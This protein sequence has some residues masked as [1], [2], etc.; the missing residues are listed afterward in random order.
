[1]VMLILWLNEWAYHLEGVN[2]MDNADFYLQDLKSK[3][4]KIN[5]KEYYLSYSGGKD[6]HL[7]YWFIKEY[8][9][10]FSNIKVIGINTYLEHPEIRDRIY[11]YS[12][13]V[14]LPSKIPFEIKEEFGIPCFSKEQD[15]FIYFG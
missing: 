13:K 1:M 5:P 6:S 2:N 4:N 9:K 14:L 10:E 3:F 7:L 12:D 11:K 8:A 15:F